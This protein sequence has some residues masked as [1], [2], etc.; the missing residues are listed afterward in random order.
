MGNRTLKPCVVRSRR[1]AHDD[2]SVPVCFDAPLD[3]REFGIIEQF[4][5]P[6][7]VELRLVSPCWQLNYEARHMFR[8][9]ARYSGRQ[10]RFCAPA[11][12]TYGLRCPPVFPFDMRL[13]AR[14]GS[15]SILR[16]FA[17][18]PRSEEN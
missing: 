15:G 4:L 16:A 7:Q 14:Q 6:A 8:I 12:G 9:R 5:P 2:L 13:A 10:T 1:W 3:A 11:S 17:L 18:F